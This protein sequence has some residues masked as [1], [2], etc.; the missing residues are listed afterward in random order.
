MS[1]YHQEV[2]RVEERPHQV[3]RRTRPLLLAEEFEVFEADGQFLWQYTS[4][5]LS[6]FT[7]DGP[8]HSMGSTP[9]IEGNRLWIISMTRWAMACDSLVG[10]SEATV[11]WK[12]RC[13]WSGMPRVRTS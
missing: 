8:Q 2:A 7:E 1:V 5:R 12:S 9:L 3:L 4:P 10:V 11:R 13:T 6:S